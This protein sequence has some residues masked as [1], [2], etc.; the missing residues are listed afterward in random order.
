M[1]TDNKTVREKAVEWLDKMDIRRR[2][3]YFIK[4]QHLIGKDALVTPE[5]KEKIYLLEHQLPQR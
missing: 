1:H 3:E 4:H 5:V 2:Q